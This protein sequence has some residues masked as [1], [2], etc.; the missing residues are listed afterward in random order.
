MSDNDPLTQRDG[1]ALTQAIRELTVEVRSLPDKIAEIY[2]RKDVLA[3]QL[4]IIDTR[5][6]AQ[7]KTIDA[8]SSIFTWIARIVVGLIIVG[9][10]GLLFTSGGARGGSG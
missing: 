2:V 6:A 1:N 4:K 7:S 9:L 3:A 10:V 8:H 5:S